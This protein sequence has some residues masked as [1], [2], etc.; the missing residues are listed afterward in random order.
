MLHIASVMAQRTGRKDNGGDSIWIYTGH[1]ERSS[2]S[3]THPSDVAGSVIE[4]IG[5]V[6]TK[7]FN[8]SSPFDFIEEGTHYNSTE[9]IIT[10]TAKLYKHSPVCLPAHRQIARWELEAYVRSTLKSFGKI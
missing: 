5:D 4:R 2:K 7:K 9:E 6:G 3:L 1:P 8:K 10:Y